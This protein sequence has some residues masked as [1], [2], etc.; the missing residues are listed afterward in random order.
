MSQSSAPVLLVDSNRDGLELYATALALAGIRADAVNS[1]R[2]ALDKVAASRPRVLV[3]G[4]RLQGS[5][6]TRLIAR[7]RHT[8]P[9]G[10]LFIVGLSTNAA[11]ESQAARDAGADVVLPVPCLP[12]TLVGE[13]RRVL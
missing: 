6:A 8:A 7:V 2:E 3:T 9:R 10:R 5:D 1:A 11:L 12:E 4:L 13:L